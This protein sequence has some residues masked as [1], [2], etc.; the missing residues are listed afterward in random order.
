M[1]MAAGLTDPVHAPVSVPNSEDSV[2]EWYGNREL[3][4][5]YV[6]FNTGNSILE[7]VFV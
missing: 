4:E 2:P 5:S 1:K 6:T 3:S 7:T